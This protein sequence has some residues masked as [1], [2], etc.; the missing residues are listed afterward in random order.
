MELRVRRF[1]PNHRAQQAPNNTRLLAQA[2]AFGEGEDRVHEAIYT[3]ARSGV[4]KKITDTKRNDLHL[5]AW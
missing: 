1:E 2:F 4:N 3:E 5:G